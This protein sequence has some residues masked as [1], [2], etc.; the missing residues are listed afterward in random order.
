M[1]QLF[2]FIHQG[3]KHKLKI[4][5]K[6]ALKRRYQTSRWAQVR[7]FPTGASGNL[8]TAGLSCETLS[9]NLST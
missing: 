9:K 5:E 7:L 3:N 8:T 6:E 4:A 2:E 1:I